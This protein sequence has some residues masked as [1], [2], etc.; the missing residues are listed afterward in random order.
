M[1]PRGVVSVIAAIGLLV[2]LGI[3]ALAIDIGYAFLQKTRM[4]A[5]ADASALACVLQPDVCGTGG[6]DLFPAVNPHAASVTMTA[7]VSCPSPTLQEGCARAVAAVDWNTY[8]LGLFGQPVFSTQAVA[9]AGRASGLASCITTLSEFRANGTNI[10]TLNNC[11]A[12]VG[13]RLITTNQS[14]ISAN[15]A[16]TA[17]ITVYNGNDPTQCGNCS[18]PPIGQEGPLPDLPSNTIPTRNFDGTPLP[19]RSSSECRSGTCLPGIYRGGPVRLSGTTTL[20]SGVYVFEQGFNVSGRTLRGQPNGVSIYIPGDAPLDLT[21][22]ITLTAPTPAG[23][24]PGS[25]IVLSHPYAGRAQTMSLEGSNVQLNLTGVVNL[26][27]D[28]ITIRGSSSSFNLSGTLVA[29]SIDLRGNM[30]PAISA[31]PCNNLY[32]TRKVVLVE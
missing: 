32:Q 11:S 22:N 12:D 15:K 10:L 30:M 1:P 28:A 18:P 9:V 23:C 2:V 21:G 4:Q 14:G 24:A 6:Q 5:V 3:G 26:G 17:A 27:A 16:S 25:G 7:P 13:G 19:I 31:N 8:F 20:T 29:H